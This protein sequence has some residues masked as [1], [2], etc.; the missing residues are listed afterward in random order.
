MN[1]TIDHTLLGP[2]TNA[3]AISR[4][5]SEAKEYNF[6]AVC[7]PPYF[8]SQA[9]QELQ[10][11]E[12]KVATV[13][14]FPHGFA[15]TMAKVEEIK[16]AVDEG[17]DEID[18][19]INLNALK[20]GDWNHVSSDID[21]MVTAVRLRGKVL[22]LIVESSLLDED[23][24]ARVCDI[25]NEVSPDYVKTSTGLQGGATEDVIRFLRQHLKP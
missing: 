18:A 4:L 9:K 24:L 6:C 12:V 7:V 19:V 2:Q 22:K 25:C 11:T 20:S 15:A 23:E 14:G 16:R 13:V 10:G 3:T 17:V 5:C 8:V 21:R 1:K